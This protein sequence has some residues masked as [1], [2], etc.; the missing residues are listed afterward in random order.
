MIVY[1]DDTILSY[2]YKR[3]ISLC[4]YFTISFES[5]L[6]LYLSIN[7]IMYVIVLQYVKSYL[8]NSFVWKNSEFI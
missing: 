5:Y 7:R 8:I 6:D 2:H 4:N 1:F 3:L